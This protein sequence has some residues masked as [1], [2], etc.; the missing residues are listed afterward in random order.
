MHT[1]KA[2]SKRVL[3]KG[4]GRNALFNCS[5]IKENHHQFFYYFNYKKTT[6]HIFDINLKNKKC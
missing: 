6:A 1:K 2:F 3:E 5:H 4:E